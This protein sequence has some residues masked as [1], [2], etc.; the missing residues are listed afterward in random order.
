MN[1]MLQS[2]PAGKL[3]KVLEDF[4]HEVYCLCDTALLLQTIAQ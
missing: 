1:P 4:F 3:L 2:Y